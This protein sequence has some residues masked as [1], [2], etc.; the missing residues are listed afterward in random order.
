VLPRPSPVAR[1]TPSPTAPASDPFDAWL[2]SD[3]PVADGFDFSVGDADGH[4]G[5]TDKQTRRAY[6]GWYVA[7]KF[8]EHYALGLHPG[9][10]W[11]GTGGGDTDLGQDVHAVAHG[12]VAFAGHCGA[13]WGNVV[14]IDHLFYESP[15]HPG[16]VEAGVDLAGLTAWRGY[17]LPWLDRR[18]GALRPPAP[19]LGLRGDAKRGPE[20]VVRS[21]SRGR[22]GRDLL[23]LTLCSQRE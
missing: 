9:E 7:T 15:D 23:I 4:G 16:M 19:L 21:H 18:L 11:N 2:L 22:H 13:P 10:D 14:M 17:R 8:A 5:Y 1:P 3:L 12:R 6:E 20:R